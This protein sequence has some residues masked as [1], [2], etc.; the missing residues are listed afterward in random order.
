M[1]FFRLLLPPIYL[2]GVLCLHFGLVV[3]K[4]PL[5]SICNFVWCLLV[6]ADVYTLILFMI[7]WSCS[8]FWHPV[9]LL[10]CDQFLIHFLLGNMLYF[11]APGS[12]YFT[13]YNFLFLF[14]FLNV[15]FVHVLFVSFLVPSGYNLCAV[16]NNHFWL[17]PIKR[18]SKV[19]FLEKQMLSNIYAQRPTLCGCQI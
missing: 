10:S 1:F 17:F 4:E 6:G 8:A 16:G 3:V 11:L 7:S 2:K 13:C 9:L 14:H 5:S 12:P 15:L 18:L 19:F